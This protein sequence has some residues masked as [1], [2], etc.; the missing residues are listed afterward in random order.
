MF[1]IAMIIYFFAIQQSADIF[2]TLF[3]KVI[4][5]IRTLILNPLSPARK[6]S[7]L[8]GLPL[9]HWTDEMRLHR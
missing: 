4:Y 9:L 8:S 6:P 2:T 3:F 5:C 7:S 1:D